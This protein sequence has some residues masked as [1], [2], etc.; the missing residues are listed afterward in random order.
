MSLVDAYSIISCQL[1]KRLIEL[2]VNMLAKRCSFGVSNLI[3]VLALTQSASKKEQGMRYRDAQTS[4]FNMETLIMTCPRN[5]I[6]PYK[7]CSYL[8]L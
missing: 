5:K 3:V 4:F 7:I 1:L 6:F 2:L 8:T